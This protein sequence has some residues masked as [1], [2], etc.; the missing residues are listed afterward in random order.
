MP[1]KLVSL[2]HICEILKIFK[3]FTILKLLNLLKLLLILIFIPFMI[4]DE[5]WLVGLTMMC[6]AQAKI[7]FRI[8]LAR[9]SLR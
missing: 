4:A 5:W 8:G 9:F 1:T 7:K 3:L 6:Q 2:A